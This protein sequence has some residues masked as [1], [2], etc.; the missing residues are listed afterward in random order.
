MRIKR[1][2]NKTKRGWGC[3]NNTSYVC[4]DCRT[5]DRNG[6]GKCRVCHKEMVMLF[7][8][9]KVPKKT[10]DKAWKDLEKRMVLRPEKEYKI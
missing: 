6:G 8:Y 4:F 10:N 5:C 3:L 9:I 2:K 7:T 1:R